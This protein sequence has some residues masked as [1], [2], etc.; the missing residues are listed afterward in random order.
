MKTRTTLK[1]REANY[2]KD[3]KRTLELYEVE[4]TRKLTR[5]EL[6]FIIEFSVNNRDRLTTPENRRIALGL[7]TEC[8]IRK[9]KNNAFYTTN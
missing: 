4:K 7:I 5:E 9:S 6:S 2:E 3:L 1:E 8:L